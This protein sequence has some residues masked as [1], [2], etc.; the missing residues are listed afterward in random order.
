MG[1]RA[2]GIVTAVVLPVI[3]FQGNNGILAFGNL[4]VMFG[5]IHPQHIGFRTIAFGRRHGIAVHADEQI[6]SVAVGNRGPFIEFD[7][8]V[9]IAGI[10]D[11]YGGA[12]GLQVSAQFEDNGQGI[13]FFIRTGTQAAGVLAAMSGVEH[14]GFDAVARCSRI[15]GSRCGRGRLGHKPGLRTFAP[16][17]DIR[18]VGPFGNA[19]TAIG[20]EKVKIL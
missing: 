8:F 15:N 14:H 3:I 1:F 4:E 9:L 2:V 6:G 10:N 19:S 7:E 20:R 16:G 5:T 12:I 18:P 13:I 11:F 17:P